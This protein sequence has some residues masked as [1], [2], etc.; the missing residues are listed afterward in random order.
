[1]TSSGTVSDVDLV[2][3]ERELAARTW[4]DNPAGAPIA[5]RAIKAV[6]TELIP[7]RRQTGTY[8][9]FIEKVVRP[10][11]E[12][13]TQRKVVRTL[14]LTSSADGSFSFTIDVPAADHA[15]EV[16]LSTRDA[17]GRTA[18]RM[19]VIGETPEPWRLSAGIAFQTT[20]GR[21]TW[22]DEYAVGDRIAWR[23][24]DNT[25][26]LPSGGSNRY[27]YIVAQR[28]LVDVATSLTPAFNRTFKASDAPGIFVM[29]IRFTGETYAPKAASWAVFKRSSRALDVAVT[30]DQPVYRPGGKMTLTI[31]T[32][33]PAGRPT[34]AEV[35]VQVVDEKLFAIDG[36]RAPMTLDEL[37]TKVDSGIVRL[38]STHQLPSTGGREGEGGDTTGGG[39]RNDFRDTLASRSVTTGVDGLA[40]T[41]VLLS[42]DLTSWHVLASAVTGHL[43]TG[44]GEVLVPV[45]LPLWADVTLA[46]GYLLSDRPTIR[47]RAYGGALR[48]GDPVEYTV[49]AP[50]L[51][52][53]S[54][55]IRARAFTDVP[56]ELPP[57][58][59]GRHDVH[60]SVVAPTRLDSAG[61]PLRD[62]LKRPIDVVASRLTKSEAWYGTVGDALPSVDSPDAATYTFTD[63]GRGRYLQLLLDA[64]EPAG[65]RL[66]R[67][68]A[69]DLAR[70]VLISQFGSD[71]LAF[72]GDP[73][74]PGLYTIGQVETGDGTIQSGAGL[75]PHAGP[76]PWLAARLAMLD[77]TGPIAGPLLWTLEAIRDDGATLRDLRIAALAGL[78]A[79][80]SPV[81]ADLRDALAMTDLTP[82]ERLSL[83]MGL[84]AI[85]DHAAALEL[86]RG[87][88]RAYGQRLGGWVRLRIGATQDEAVDATAR[89]AVLAAG[90][91][92]PL[93]PAMIDF[94]VANP[95]SETSNVLELVAAAA[96]ALER[97]PAAT[98]SFAYVL[99][100]TRHEVTIQPGDA[101]SLV[102]T[103]T[104]RRSFRLESVFG[105]VGV[106][107]SWR[108]SVDVSALP[109]DPALEL[110][111]DLPSVTLAPDRIVTV[112][113]TARFTAAAPRNGCYEVVEQVPSGL[114]PLVS[115]WTTDTGVI[116]PTTV[117]GQEV[118]F[119]A[120]NQLPGGSTAHLRYVARVV[121]AGTFTWEPAIMQLGV[122][123]ELSAT[124]PAGSVTIRPK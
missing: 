92:D 105:K 89:L 13:D 109:T 28:G 66:D 68:L 83:G 8:Y 41:T 11:Y 54:T 107:I 33:D 116:W 17:A 21:Y 74:D 81:D 19:L 120:P 9:D 20:S 25:A 50:S 3:V 123:S 124:S 60:V 59:L 46:D 27:L 31:R 52:L 34:P 104:Q 70:T 77:P 38:T 122:A 58:R 10:R 29:G 43:E 96:H 90:L 14:A 45:G 32:T 119:C 73:P 79:L 111:R 86:E 108:A 112:N 101:M 62:S 110:T 114:A 18:R 44:V 91:G 24:T 26:A 65:L 82:D 37:Y 64:S 95:S 88:L 30:A 94:V 67:A 23:M 57:L 98:A 5:G 118:R 2:R 97:T 1:L 16:T 87:L 63:A 39:E 12:Y 76:D 103:D 113:L 48:A 7:T 15:Y 36:A 40:T 121:N 4:D 99:D 56:F 72:I 47:L 106:V 61:R 75:V 78:A 85:G 84:M 55:V 93:A 80:G 71:P 115:A 117:V 35:I 51:G 100:G 22:Q 69:Q 49:S 42:D 53:A 102:L 6:V